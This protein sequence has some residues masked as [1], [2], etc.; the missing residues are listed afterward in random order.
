MKKLLGFAVGFVFSLAGVLLW[1]LLAEVG[2]IASIAASAI[3][4]LFFVGYKLVNPK[5]EKSAIALAC[6]VTVLDIAGI[7]LFYILNASVA[8]E[9]SVA[10]LIS[11]YPD[12]MFQEL[13]YFLV[14]LLFGGLGIF[15]FIYQQKRKSLRRESNGADGN[16][17]PPR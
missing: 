17:L 11:R 4:Y 6:I 8:L 5:N 7:S 1:V 14:G 15:S 3:A 2:F 12:E 16:R 9:L 13:M 10:D